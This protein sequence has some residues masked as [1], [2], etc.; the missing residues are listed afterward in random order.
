[1]MF[2]DVYIPHLCICT[3][4]KTKVVVCHMLIEILMSFYRHMLLAEGVFNHYILTV[5]VTIN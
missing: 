5:P 1:M 2:G 3:D 4:K